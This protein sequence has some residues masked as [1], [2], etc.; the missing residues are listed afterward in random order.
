MLEKIELLVALVILLVSVFCIFNARGVVKN[1]VKDDNI[2][3]IVTIVKIISTLIAIICLVA[4][5]FIK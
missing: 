3:K 2:N 5:Y 1:R 4:I